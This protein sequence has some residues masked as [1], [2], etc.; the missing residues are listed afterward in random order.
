MKASILTAIAMAACVVA[1]P[2][3][4]LAQARDEVAARSGCPCACPSCD[5]E[6]GVPSVPSTGTPEPE[7]P[8]G[9]PPVDVP[10]V[11]GGPSGPG[12][13]VPEEPSVPAPGGPGAP[14]PEEPSVPAP[15]GPGAPTVPEEPSVPAPNGSGGPGAPTTPEVPATT[16]VP[17]PPAVP[18]SPVD[19]PTTP[20]QPPH[21]GGEDEG[22]NDDDEGDD[23]G[24]N[25]DDE[26]DDDH[27]G[28]CPTCGNKPEPCDE[29]GCHGTGHLIQDLGPQGKKL[30]T[31][32]GLDSQKLLVSL[33]PA[34]THL[35]EGL[36]L[37]GLGKPVG[38]VI[39]EA[40]TVG[41]LIADLGD[42]IECLLTVVGQDTGYLL[43][44]LDPGLA[45]LLKGLGLPS[46]A[47]PVGNLIGA[48]GKSLKRQDGLLEDIAPVV[49]CILRIVGD[50]LQILLVRLSGPVA[51]LVAGLGLTTLAEPVGE[52]IRSAATVGELVHDLGPVVGCLLTVVG[53]DGELLLV[54]LAPAV[55]DLVS[56]LGL[57]A[58]GVPVGEVINALGESI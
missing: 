11:P 34:V 41:E 48:V 39:K 21:Q 29:E 25:D 43:I 38:E 18:S 46:I 28:G 55:A 45:G 6:P 54:R 24:D 36:G 22:D 15:G 52:V 3:G 17:N 12:A 23:E 37:I 56:G 47:N 35:L 13:P 16:G 30:L 53:E 7:K 8:S 49:D 57:P 10:G 40:A 50:D 44:R 33:S 20:E 26:G 2:M 4:S 27:E 14:V 42:P 19:T 31:V 1:S 58:L 51:E 9:P 5:D 32:I